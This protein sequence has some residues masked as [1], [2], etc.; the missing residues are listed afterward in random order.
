LALRLRRV[1]GGEELR[2]FLRMPWEVYRG[3][4][5]WVPPLLWERRRFLSPRHNP[6]FEH[7]EVE[8]W[9][10]E[11][12]GRPVGRI[13][14]VLDHHWLE[15]RGEAMGGFG[16][17]EC[18]ERLD[19]ARALLGRVADWCRAR[20]LEV[21]RGPFSLSTNHECGLLVEG[22]GMPPKFMM[23]Y[24]PPYYAELLEA[25][26]LRKAKDLLAWRLDMGH[27]PDLEERLG[28]LRRRLRA[29]VRSL[30]LGDF[31][32]DLE[33][34]WELYR[35]A[36]SENWGF[37]PP[38]ERE[39]RYLAEAFRRVAD[40]ALAL[41]AEVDGQPVGVCLSVPDLN[42]VLIKM[43]GRLF[44]WGFLHLWGWRRRVR[45]FRGVLLG[46]RRG[47]RRR[48]VELL[49]QLE[50]K[51]VALA[52]GYREGEMSWVLEDNLPVNNVLRRAGAVAY[53]RYR[54]Y[55]LELP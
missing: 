54:I 14:A 23:P 28:R 22:F 36:W 38:T 34:L 6:F 40:P 21:L 37:V 52:R 55:E 27:T 44:P 29:R 41:I 16:L 5:C 51:R 50:T 7:A 33:V 3:D 18:L 42:E 4:P 13:A 25:C 39:F 46:V 32:R 45:S 15:Y 35:D 12:D 49:L 31:D 10:A 19:V 20:D 53:K 47:Y 43:G 8:L 26:G 30:R 17:F 1:E 9:L 2:R 48:G 24:N 11:E